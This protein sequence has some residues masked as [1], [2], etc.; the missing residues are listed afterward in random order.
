[1]DERQVIQQMMSVYGRCASYEDQGYVDT[2]HDPGTT[3]ERRERILFRTMFKRPNFFR[4]EWR[5]QD[6]FSKAT[7]EVEYLVCDGS[8]AYAHSRFEQGAHECE[9]LDHAIATASGA[10]AHNVSS[11]LMPDF[12]AIRFLRD[13][14]LSLA[15]SEQLMNDACFHVLAVTNVQRIDIYIS[16]QTRWLR[17]IREDRLIKSSQASLPELPPGISA[18][19]REAMLGILAEA[20]IGDLHTITDS[21]YTHI[22]FDNP[23]PDQI[24]SPQSAGA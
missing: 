13:G 19:D 16:E 7:D 9:S 2:I 6:P 23:I 3:D 21:V 14:A 10:N 18:E 15:P 17:R 11:L 8:R 12:L 1:M 4:L 24:F 5:K 20:A 22:R